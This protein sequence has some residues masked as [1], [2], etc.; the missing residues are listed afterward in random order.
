MAL[1]EFAN[2]AIA[3]LDE[4][5]DYSIEQFGEDA[6]QS[7]MHGFKEAFAQLQDYPRSGQ[8]ATELGKSMRCLTHRRHRIFYRIEAEQVLILRILHKAMDAKRQFAS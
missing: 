7:Y 5:D 2:A 8:P 6:A 1:V 4:I 3:D